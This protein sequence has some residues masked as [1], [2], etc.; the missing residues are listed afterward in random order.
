MILYLACRKIPFGN[1]VK[2]L[3][4]VLKSYIDKLKKSSVEEVS[5]ES[6]FEKDRE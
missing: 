4:D 6:S 2:V 1:R 3:L 5:N